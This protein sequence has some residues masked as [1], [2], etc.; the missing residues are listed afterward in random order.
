MRL[1]AAACWLAIA[2]CSGPNVPVSGGTGGGGSSTG[3]R[4]HTSGGVGSGGG[5]GTGAG[6]GTS[7]GS[8]SGGSSGGSSLCVGACEALTGSSCG[9]IGGWESSC[10]SLCNASPAAISCLNSSGS[11]C[12]SLALCYFQA[13]C[14][15]ECTNEPCVPGGSETCDEAITCANACSGQ[16]VDCACGCQSGLSSSLGGAF[17]V[18]SACSATDC[19]T[20]CSP[21][22]TALSCDSCLDKSCN[23]EVAVCAAK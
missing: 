16:G 15:T 18:A 22:G 13:L 6:T 8:S 19:A 5:T 7:G 10:V 2:A 11:D 20:E 23:S 9:V 21:T 1:S 3:G 4:V 14:A 17:L 12:N